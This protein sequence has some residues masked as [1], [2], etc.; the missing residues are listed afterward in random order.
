MALPR[1]AFADLLDELLDVMFVVELRLTIL[2]LLVA[3]VGVVAV[4]HLAGRILALFRAFQTI[5]S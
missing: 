3:L 2:N 1:F 5:V 4:E